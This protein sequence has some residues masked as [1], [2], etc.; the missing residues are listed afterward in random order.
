MVELFQGRV[1]FDL[2]RVRIFELDAQPTQ[3]KKRLEW[4]TRRLLVDWGDGCR[5]AG[6]PTAGPTARR[7]T[8]GQADHDGDANPA[9][10][11]W[12]TFS[13]RPSGPR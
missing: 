11:G 8:A 7:G 13:G 1:P 4:A 9:L 12:L 5:A 6:A 3:A 2:L 10:P